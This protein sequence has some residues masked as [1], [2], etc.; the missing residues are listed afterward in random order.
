MSWCQIHDSDVIMGAMASQITGVSIVYPNVCSDEYQRKY[1]SSASLAFVRGI[2]R[3]PVNSPH[4]WPV[5]RKMFPFDD[6]IMIRWKLWGWWLSISLLLHHCFFFWEESTGD[7][8]IPQQRI[9]N[10]ESN[11]ISCFPLWSGV[12]GPIRWSTTAAGFHSFIGFRSRQS[13][14]NHHRTLLNRQ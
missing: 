7:R 14:D 3:W 11:S 4:K 6:V 12:W 2:H 13:I 8:W 5:T 1:H 10:G 9:N